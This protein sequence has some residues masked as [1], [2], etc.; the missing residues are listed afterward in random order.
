MKNNIF[1]GPNNETVFRLKLILNQITWWFDYI[2]KVMNIKTFNP[3]NSSEFSAS[4]KQA[5]FTFWVCGISLSQDQTGSVYF[6]ISQKDTSYVYIGSTLCLRTDLRKYDPGGF[7][8]DTDILI[9]L[10]P[11]VLIAYS[12]GFRKDRQMI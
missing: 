1:V 7:A 12:C 4:L 10:R 2:E 11:F 9:H 8:S 6:L 3:N 5:I